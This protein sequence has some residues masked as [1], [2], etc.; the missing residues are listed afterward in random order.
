[1]EKDNLEKYGNRYLF[2]GLEDVFDIR[3][4]LPEEYKRDCTND[5]MQC[6][7][8]YGEMAM[9]GQTFIDCQRPDVTIE[10]D[11]E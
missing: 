6:F 1:M 10:A 7:I 3:P 5:P 2:E 8:C 11:N 9:Y 4:V